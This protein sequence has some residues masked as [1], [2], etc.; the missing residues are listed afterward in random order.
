ML[1]PTEGE[2]RVLQNQVLAVPHGKL[3][4]RDGQSGT[5]V[6]QPVSDGAQPGLGLLAVA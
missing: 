1:P 6:T 3:R 5:K 2:L 4:P